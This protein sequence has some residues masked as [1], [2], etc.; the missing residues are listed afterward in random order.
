MTSMKTNFWNQNTKNEERKEDK[1]PYSRIFVVCSKQLQEDDLKAPFEKFGDIEDLYIPRDRNTGESKGVAYI[2]YNKT[3]SAAAAIE[4][5]HMKILKNAQKPI[6]VMVAANKNDIQSNN[7]EKYKRLFIKVH[8]EA[9]ESEIR[10]HFSNFGNVD[11]VHLQ[12]NRLTNICKGFAYVN[13]ANFLDAAKAFENC[14]RKYRPVFATPKDELKRSR[15]SLEE[16]GM[17]FVESPQLN[18]NNTR[19]NS[20]EKYNWA[21]NGVHKDNLN[22][23]KVPS[24]N[25]DTVNV[26]CSPQVSQKH[27][28]KLFNIVPGMTQCQYTTD[29]YNGVCKA[30]ITYEC[31]KAAAYA[32]ER[33]NNFE[34]P[35]GE[36]VSVK[37]DDNPLNKAASTLT[38]IVNS[39]RNSIDAGSS[40]RELLQ[41]ADAIA[42]ASSLIKAATSGKADVKVDQQNSLC[43]VPLPPLQPIVNS[44]SRVAQRCFIVCKPCPPPNTVLRDAFCRFGDLIDVS[45]FPN[46][47]FGFAK[48][49]SIKSAQEAITTLN[50]AV[51]SGIKLKV[52]EADEKPTKNDDYKM[53]VEESNDNYPDYEKETRKR[54]KIQDKDSNAD[55]DC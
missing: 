31:E 32:V 12:R 30:T 51:L 16:A 49:A 34:F 48:Y 41:L 27:I 42:Q 52:M 20:F 6:K 36:I 14:D 9:S 23:I 50:G 44:N 11:S 17:N 2:K 5:L 55:N 39:F 43:S 3:S 45:T 19:D 26:T 10:E 47:T 4:E 21:H 25:Y 24:Q 22:L 18:I 15:N 37:P 28:E 54:M 38:T 7:E 1:P 46:K 13:Y 8:K 53:I 40:G 29:A 33:L 35:S